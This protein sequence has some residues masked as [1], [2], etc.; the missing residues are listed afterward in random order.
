[1]KLATLRRL[2]MAVM[3]ALPLPLFSASKSTSQELPPH[4]VLQAVYDGVV[5]IH[6]G[7]AV[8]RVYRPIRPGTPTGC[9][10]MIPENAIYCKIDHSIYIST[11]MVAR[12]Y[13]YGDAA[14]AYILGHEY[15][16]AM[17]NVHGINNNRGPVSELQADCLA[18]FYMAAMPNVVFDRRDV[19]EIS[20][21]A[22]SLGD[23]NVWSQDH[24]GT[25]AQRMRAVQI[26]LGANNI[27]A[28]R[29]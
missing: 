20:A 1:M 23:N 16:H 8:P 27:S 3:L 21:F 18:G 25:P 2:A 13:R 9:G 17:Q 11:D 19:Q 26:G 4:V 10:P 24:H 6:G 28:C 14:L 15:A 29:I 7:V 12:A 22:Y 5:Y